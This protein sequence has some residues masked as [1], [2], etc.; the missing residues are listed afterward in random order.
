MILG[1]RLASTTG[2][3]PD[4]ELSGAASEMTDVI[5]TARGWDNTLRPAM[6]TSYCQYNTTLNQLSFYSRMQVTN[7]VL[8]PGVSYTLR[9]NIS[10]KSGTTITLSAVV[11][12]SGGTYASTTRTVTGW[13]ELTFTP[14]EAQ[15]TITTRIT[16]SENST[17]YFRVSEIEFYKT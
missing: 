12:D 3:V 7:I 9:M 8:R 5:A 10:A 4:I 13:M 17:T 16:N 15:N 11:S 2:P 14:T 6:S 1:R